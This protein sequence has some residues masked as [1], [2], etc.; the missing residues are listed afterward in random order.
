VRIFLSA[1]NARTFRTSG[2]DFTA[3]LTYSS[4][5][6]SR[7]RDYLDNEAR[8]AGKAKNT[9]GDPIKLGSKLLAVK[10]DPL[11][12]DAVFV[13]E[14]VGKVSHVDLKVCQLGG[15]WGVL[16]ICDVFLDL[17]KPPCKNAEFNT[18]R[19]RTHYVELANIRLLCFFI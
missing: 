16:V 10:A 14:A 6:Q 4:E 15:S 9:A 3:L 19:D 11:R 13:A 7:H 18:A 2:L 12:D 5:S 1:F 8:K 17:A